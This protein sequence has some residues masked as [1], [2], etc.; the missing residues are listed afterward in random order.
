M[1][2][3][4]GKN[5]GRKNRQTDTCCILFVYNCSFKANKSSF[6]SRAYLTISLS[7]LIKVMI[8]EGKTE[9]NR[10]KEEDD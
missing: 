3:G 10:R 8:T 9:N 4:R 1:K 5:G 6:T 7:T 2:E